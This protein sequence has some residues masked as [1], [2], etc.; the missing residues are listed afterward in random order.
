MLCD[1]SVKNKCLSLL[2]KK[3]ELKRVAYLCIQR[4]FAVN[5]SCNCNFFSFAKRKKL[6]FN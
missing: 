4:C 2:Q 3:A 6:A 1:G 5:Y